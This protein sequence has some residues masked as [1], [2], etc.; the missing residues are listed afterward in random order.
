MKTMKL[1]LSNVFR[2]KRRTLITL[3]SIISA[4]V[5]MIVFGGFITYTFNGLREL[6]ILTQL[7]HFQLGAAGYFEKGAGLELQHILNNPGEIEQKLRTLPHIRTVTQRLSGSGLISTGNITLT[8]SL[9]GIEPEKEQAFTH[10]ERLVA[11]S[12]LGTGDGNECVVGEGLAKGLNARLGDTLTI[13][14]TT[15]E[16]VINASECRLAGIV[17]TGA[18]AYDAVYVKLHLKQLQGLLDTQGIEKLLVLL[19]D[20]A[21]VPSVEPQLRLYAKEKALDLRMWEELAEYYRGVVNVYTSIFRFS[22]CVLAVV[23]LLSIANTMSMCVFE[24]FREIGTLRAIG[25]SRAGIMKLFLSEGLI[26]GVVGG[27]AG[28]VAGIVAA[29]IINA[30][31]GIE[32]STP[33]GM[34]AGYT[35]LITP[36]S[37]YF[38]WS[39]G[40]SVFASVGASV[41]PAYRASRLDIV[42]ALQH[43]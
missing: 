39:F 14:S 29:W 2:N 11:G 20:T 15:F 19:D 16:G 37:A 4:S 6:T 17:R 30:A 32:I 22:A 24:R 8:G 1:A 36:T 7:G 9:L 31:G 38:L 23:V 34:S 42:K 41:F 13:L 35:A 3:L 26:I 5:A 21:N 18:K 28:I 33:P 43:V 12:Q 27:L 40:M 25:E 10:A